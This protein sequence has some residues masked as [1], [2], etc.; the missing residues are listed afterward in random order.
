[1]TPREVLLAAAALLEP[2]GAWTQTAFAKSATGKDVSAASAE[3]VSWCFMGAIRR[4][5]DGNC[6]LQSDALSA[7]RRQVPHAL[8]WHYVPG[9]TQAEVVA[10]LRAAAEGTP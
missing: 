4:I 3:A 1:M 9:R 5:A 10:M 6:W 2:D 8:I 7:V